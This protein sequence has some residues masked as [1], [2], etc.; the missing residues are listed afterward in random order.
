[1][2]LPENVLD[3]NAIVRIPPKYCAGLENDLLCGFH[4]RGQQAYMF[5]PK[6]NGG[7]VLRRAARQIDSKERAA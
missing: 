3:A 2:D 5:R 6:K 1:M 7:Y 4:D